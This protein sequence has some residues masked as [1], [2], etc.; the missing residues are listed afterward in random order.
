MNIHPFKT[1][2]AIENAPWGRNNWP[3][4][5]NG[6]KSNIAAIRLINDNAACADAD[7]TLA[8]RTSAWNENLLGRA[9]PLGRIPYIA[10]WL[11]ADKDTPIHITPDNADAHKAWYIVDADDGARIHRGLRPGVSIDA[12]LKAP[13]EDDARTLLQPVEVKRGQCYYIAPGVPHAIG[14]GVVLAEIQSTTGHNIELPSDDSTTTALLES[15]GTQP[16]IAAF[17]KRTHVT[18][19]FTTVTRLI[20]SPTFY[21][22]RVRFMGELEQ[23]IPYA[24][25][26][27]WLILEGTGSVQCA[28]QSPLPFAPGDC[29]IL[30]AN[31]KEPK[32]RTESDCVWLEITIPVESDLAAYPRPDAAYLQ[33]NEGTANHPIPLNISIDKKD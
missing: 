27:C 2:P 12:L 14:P 5:I 32:L 20:T 18:S 7:Q 25:L 4:P 29:V 1:R 21:I 16:D 26:V 28:K 31:M 24:E 9:A 22:E 10:R 17:E 6:D 3:F 13:T 15:S 30:P 23:E 19:L 8:D 33:A 11:G